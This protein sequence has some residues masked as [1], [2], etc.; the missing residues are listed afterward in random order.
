MHRGHDVLV[1][2]GH[3]AAKRAQKMHSVDCM[4]WSRAAGAG[5]GSRGGGEGGAQVAFTYLLAHAPALRPK[6]MAAVH[7]HWN[8][9]VL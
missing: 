2:D 8:E 4:G 6:R 3:G 9:T 7:H 1:K 5:R